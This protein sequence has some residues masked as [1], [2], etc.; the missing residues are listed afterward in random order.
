MKRWKK[1]NNYFPM[2]RYLVRLFCRSGA[3]LSL[4]VY[5]WSPLYVWRRKSF[6]WRVPV[7]WSELVWRRKSFW[8]RVPVWWSEPV[9]RWVSIWR[10][11]SVWRSLSVGSSMSIWCCMM[12]VW[13]R[14][15]VG[16]CAGWVWSRCA[17]R[18]GGRGYVRLGGAGV[19]WRKQNIVTHDALQ[20]RIS[21][22]GLK[23]VR[24]AEKLSSKIPDLYHL[25]PIWSDKRRNLTPMFS[26]MRRIKGTKNCV[27][28]W[29]FI[30]YFN[31]GQGYLT[32]LLRMLQKIWV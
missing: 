21:D 10:S 32:S 13:W 22:L 11:R 6:W 25:V 30:F 4:L 15:S 23:W 26:R 7:W 9:W 31:N 20:P 1:S 17:A 24:L 12:S 27:H 8:W 19:R 28:K 16:W 5:W 29:S 2:K 18:W 14:V 3:V